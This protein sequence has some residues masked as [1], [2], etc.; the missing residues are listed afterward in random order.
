MVDLPRAVDDLVDAATREAKPRALKSTVEKV[1]VA[2]DEAAEAPRNAAVRTIGRALGDIR[3]RGAQILSL[4]L[5]A[6]VEGGASPEVTWPIVGANLKGLLDSATSFARAAVEESNDEHVETAIEAVGAAVA[7]KRPREAAAW[8]ALP[9]RC[10]A[11]VACLTRSKKLRRRLTSDQA[12]HEASWP[13]SDVVA[14]VGY[15][16]QALRILDDERLLVLAPDERRGWRVEI[17]AMPSNA[18]LY[19]L[20]ADAL[21][22]GPRP[23]RLAGERPNPK[24]VTAIREGLHPTK[25]YSS[26]KVPFHLVLWTALDEHGLLPPA[27]PHATDNWIRFEGIPWDIPAA[28]G[29][30]RVVLIQRAPRPLR[31]VPVAP[32]FESL[33]PDLRVAEELSPEEVRRTLLKLGAHAARPHRATPTASTKK[34]A[35]SKKKRAAKA[36]TRARA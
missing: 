31:P 12:L 7:A 28:P 23:G 4:A 3:G 34:A 21:L 26:A 30:E 33:R 6:L 20:L 5:G 1:L 11:A 25:R 18:E 10:L 35:R 22:G 36:K 29:K 14:E 17:D 13:L 32:S 27:D 8:K 9:S 24:T 2:F 15:L 16:L 19:I